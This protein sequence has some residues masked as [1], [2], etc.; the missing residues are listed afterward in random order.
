MADESPPTTELADSVEVPDHDTSPTSDDVEVNRSGKDAEKKRT[1][2]RVKDRL[3][4]DLAASEQR[5][6]RLIR[7]V[8]GVG[9]IAVLLLCTTIGFAVARQ[10]AASD[11]SQQRESV[12]SRAALVEQARQAAEG[13]ATRA[14]TID[15][16]NA[17][18]FVKGLSSGTTD[19]FGKTFSLEPNGAG[20]LTKELLEQLR[21]VSEGE[22]VYAFLDG[23][24]T[25]DR[26]SGDPWNFVVLARQTSTTTQQPE[27]TTTAVILRVVVVRLDGK[28]KVANFA[29]DPK[30]QGGDN[31]VIPGAK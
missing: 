27:R 8:V 9:A 28:W 25:A 24:V 30:V 26:K 13:Y 17:T 15:Y 2:V 1:K 10:S 23:D 31:G 21:M 6:R 19:A 3:K 16:R 12:Q 5:T 11:L 7:M 18:K 22:V 29:P 14:L 4:S 20:A